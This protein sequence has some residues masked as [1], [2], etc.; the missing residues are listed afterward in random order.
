MVAFLEKSRMGV[1]GL[2]FKENLLCVKQI[3]DD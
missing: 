3:E 1:S 2:F